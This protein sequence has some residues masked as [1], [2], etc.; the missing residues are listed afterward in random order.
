VDF[1]E[2]A[3]H[4]SQL[5]DCNP[6]SF[7]AGSRCAVKKREPTFPKKEKKYTNIV[8]SQTDLF[9]LMGTLIRKP[10]WDRRIEFFLVEAA[11]AQTPLVLLFLI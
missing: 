1:S 4:K 2:Q 10:I 6:L 5:T 9:Y 11:R 3:L 7:L 8:T